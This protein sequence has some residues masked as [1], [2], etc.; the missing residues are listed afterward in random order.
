MEISAAQ[1]TANA[2]EALYPI[3]VLI[4]ELKHEDVAYRLNAIR[5][6]STIA[7]ALGVE[8]AREELIP[9]LDESIEDE[10]EVLLALA[11]ELGNM[12]DFIGGPAFAHVL[13][14]PLENLATVEETVVREKAVESLGKVVEKCSAEQAEHYFIP[15]VKRLA[16]GDWFTSR[17]SACG[18]FTPVYKVAPTSFA[19]ELKKLFATLCHDDTP[20]V[21]RAAATNMP[22]FTKKLEKASVIKEIVPLFNA[23]AVDEQDS[24]RLLTVE[25]CIAIAEVLTHAECKVHLIASLRSLYSDKS[26]RVRYVIAEK[27]KL[28]RCR[29]IVIASPHLWFTV[30]C[31]RS[32]Q[33]N[34]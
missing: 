14:G 23:L 25:C 10:D 24:V 16:G 12:V 17:S 28:V 34:N 15:L 9:F 6:L 20:M 4:D 2:D 33:G 1:T 13:F 8:R 26:W 5:R 32:W 31:R 19:E 3:A 21:R 7:L 11:D 29:Y 27:F 22:R 18:L 30:A